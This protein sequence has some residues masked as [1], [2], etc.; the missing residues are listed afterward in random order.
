MPKRDLWSAYL[1][2]PVLVRSALLVVLLL[3]YIRP[4][5]A[6]PCITCRT[7]DC[8]KKAGV[9][10]WCGPGSDPLLKQHSGHRARDHLA[11]RAQGAPRLR[12]MPQEVPKGAQPDVNDTAQARTPSAATVTVDTATAAASPPPPAAATAAIPSSD[13]RLDAPVAH[14]ALPASDK[15]VPA[16]IAAVTPLNFVRAEDAAARRKRNG[17]IVASTA[18]GGGLAI[19]TT[20][21]ALVLT[22]LPGRCG[23]PLGAVS[24]NG[25]N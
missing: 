7:A 24:L 17:W 8:P 9:A 4:A 18:A 23:A 14:P 25:C 1:A 19:T 15:P 10:A 13:A 21:L 11:N 16:A 12:R 20:V 6:E 22:S 3:G 5:Q 2:P